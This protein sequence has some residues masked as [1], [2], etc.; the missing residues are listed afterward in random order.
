MFFLHIAAMHGVRVRTLQR[1]RNRNRTAYW[2]LG[3]RATA[4]GL[5]L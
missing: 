1:K 4:L 5:S 2:Q 3:H